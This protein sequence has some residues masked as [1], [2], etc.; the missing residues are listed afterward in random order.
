METEGARAAREGSGNQW[1]RRQRAVG[2]G[3]RARPFAPQYLCIV[4]Y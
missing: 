1:V 3:V 2:P 4:L